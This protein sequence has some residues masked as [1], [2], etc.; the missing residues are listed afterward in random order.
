MTTSS[1]TT[2]ELNRNEII[3][4]AYRK[5]GIPGEGNTL[6]TQQYTDGNMALNSVIA[7]AVTDGM[8][9]WKR[10]TLVQTPSATAQDF[11]INNA[12][13]IAG[14]FL[15]DLASGVQYELE[16]K[17][18]YDY[19]RLPYSTEGVPVN[20]TFEPSITGGTL[21]IWPMRADSGSVTNKRIVI[22]YQKKFDGFTT[23]TTDTLDFP[24][25]WT[26]AII[27]R[28]AVALAPENGIPIADRQDLKQEA[29]EYWALASSYGD[30]EGSLMIQPYTRYGKA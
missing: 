12:I 28:L 14:V 2:W 8:S 6:T 10:T 17:S 21:K 27:Y 1:F 26:Q 7:L 20:W 18:L 22:V 11:T 15:R 5:L 9:L 4:S 19:Y 23:T 29:K 24:S 30:E 3:E 13:K 16:P 25:Y